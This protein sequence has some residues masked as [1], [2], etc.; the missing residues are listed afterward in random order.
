V[1][2]QNCYNWAQQGKSRR[3]HQ[4]RPKDNSQRNCSAAWNGAPCGTGDVGDFGISEVFSRWVS[5]LLT[6][7]KQHGWELL[8]HPPFSPDLAL[9]AYH[10]FGP[11]KDHLRGHHYQ[12]DEAVH[13]AARSWLRGAGTDVYR[14]GSFNICNAGRNA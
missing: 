5:H 1:V 13:E 12:T 4:R 3:A 8:S 7:R 14:R 11:L 6:E 10:L 2:V 9:S